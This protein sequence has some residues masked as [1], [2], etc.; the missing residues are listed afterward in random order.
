MGFVWI[1]L[2]NILRIIFRTKQ[3]NPKRKRETAVKKKGIRLTI[4]QIK[5]FQGQNETLQFP[6]IV[7]EKEISYHLHK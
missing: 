7:P 3:I 5:S 6:S 4:V 1:G 2:R